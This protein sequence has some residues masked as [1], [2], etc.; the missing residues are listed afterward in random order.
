MT[1]RN[2][3]SNSTAPDLWQQEED[4]HPP[5]D[6]EIEQH[7]EPPAD[8]DI[9][10]HEEE[11]IMATTE[12]KTDPFHGNFN[13]ATK[14]GHQIYLEKTKGLPASERLELS[15]GNAAD[16]H[17]F[18]RSR[19]VRMGEIV[20]KIP[21]E[22]AADGT[23]AKSINLL[24]QYHQ[25]DLELLQREGNALYNVAIADG[26]PVPEAPFTAR[27]LS[28]GTDAT[29]K[30]DFYRQVDSSVVAKLWENCLTESGYNDL[31][32]QVDKFAYTE[33]ASGQVKYHGPTMLFLTY[34]TIDPNTVVG[35]D[36]IL[37]RLENT[38]LSSFGNDVSTMLTSMQK[39]YMTL[40]DNE[41]P[42]ENYRRLI[43]D[44]V[45]TGPNATFNAF[46]QRIV[47]DVESGIGSHA[48]ITT[49]ALII[50]CKTKYNNMDGR[51]E[52]TAVDPRDA[53][54]MALTTKLEEQADKLQKFTATALA[55]A[56]TNGG[57][58][59]NGK[60]AGFDT[61]FFQGTRVQKW[62]G[63][64]DGPTKVGPDGKKLCWCKHHVHPDG[65]WNGLYVN[66]PEDQHDR[67]VGK[68]KKTDGGGAT[69]PTQ[70]NG[71]GTKDLQLQSKL[72]EVLCTNLCMS[73]DDVEKLFEKASEN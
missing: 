49:D 10:L 62:R 59:N 13:P 7:E 50:A 39:D 24:T 69:N 23:V 9:E 30:A 26:A 14:L 17:K 5:A 64:R 37:K 20:T 12:W 25:L 60:S 55:T 31:M 46:V 63:T 57:H 53:R 16:I 42:P 45:R 8:P 65:L 47:D 32:L 1:T 43:L 41:S 44:A 58:S 19:Q 11:T 4:E 21:T 67:V 15:K 34:Q 73:S 28:P 35:L 2:L 29:D 3:R 6:L 66:H 40:K 36:N 52:W 22:R 68:F 51:N 54:I 38:K 61:E 33:A 18:F 72:K 70:N 71:G 56:V 48:T 27:T